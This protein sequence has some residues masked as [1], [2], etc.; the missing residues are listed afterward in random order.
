MLHDRLVVGVDD[1]VLQRRLLAEPRLTLKKATE[2][3]LAHETA[4]KDAKAIQGANGN[5]QVM[6]GGKP[7][8]R[9]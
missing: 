9:Y 5:P 6:T 1:I 8:H 2:I 3:A 7:S 4:L